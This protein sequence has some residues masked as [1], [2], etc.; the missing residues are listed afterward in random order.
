MPSRSFYEGELV[1][2][3]GSL[4]KT[5]IFA[6]VL[7]NDAS[8]YWIPFKK[9]PRDEKTKQVQDRIDPYAQELELN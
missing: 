1:L 4:S 8:L 7:K 3:T 6:S 9:V 5:K 2:K